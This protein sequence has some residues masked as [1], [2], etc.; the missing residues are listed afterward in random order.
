MRTTNKVK[1]GIALPPEC[2]KLMDRHMQDC[3]CDSRNELVQ[4]AV[5]HYVRCSIGKEYDNYFNTNDDSK[6]ATAINDL[7]TRLARIE[8]KIAVQ[9]AQ[10]NLLFMSALNLSWED[11]ERFKGKAVQLVKSTK[12]IVEMKDILRPNASEDD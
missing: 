12:G 11:A 5:E 4:K 1:T 6:T 3:R 10:L 9:L 2:I 8:F 7:A